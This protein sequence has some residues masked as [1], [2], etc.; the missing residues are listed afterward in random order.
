MHFLNSFHS[1]QL[2][3]YNSQLTASSCSEHSHSYLL[4]PV[5]LARA[6]SQSPSS[7]QYPPENTF[8]AIHLL[9]VSASEHTP[10]HLLH[11]VPQSEHTHRY[12]LP[13]VP[14]NTLTVTS[15]SQYLTHNTHIVTSYTQ[16]QPQNAFPRIHIMTTPNLQPT[17]YNLHI[18]A[19]SLQLLPPIQHDNNTEPIQRP[20]PPQGDGLLEF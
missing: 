12:L 7:L 8:T 2:A 20:P 17:T 4:L 15:S 5:S 10:S 9:P 18:T 6:H 11:P 13:P 1:S 19:Y 16:T 3:T 14:E